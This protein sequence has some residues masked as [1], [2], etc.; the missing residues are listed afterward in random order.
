MTPTR[1]T[2][3]ATPFALFEGPVAHAAAVLGEERCTLCGRRGLCL[4]LSIG[5]DL[6]RPCSVCGSPT[7]FAAAA[8]A[9]QCLSCATESALPAS[10]EGEAACLVCLREGRFAITK[11]S[12]LGM[13]RWRDAIAGL[14]HGRPFA[15]SADGLPIASYLGF[16]AD[17]PN[18]EGWQ[19]IRVPSD[20]LLPLVLTPDFE[21]IQG[22]VWEFH[23]GRPMAFIGR[24]GRSDF[25]DHAPDGDGASFARAV[26]DMDSAA[27][28]GLGGSG[29]DEDAPVWAYA[30]RCTACGVVAANWDAD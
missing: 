2:D 21:S 24:W 15:R 7:D 3:L 28:D 14:T 23:C 4:E 29:D 6:I 11:D 1:F 17:P 26:A 27:F 30:F 22:S 8:D 19:S 5:H 25:V 16:P 20:V 10:V 9:Q 13:V 12:D 18:A